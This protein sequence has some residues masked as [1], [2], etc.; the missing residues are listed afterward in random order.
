MDD[1]GI[2]IPVTRMGQ[3]LYF[4]AHGGDFN[5]LPLPVT[6]EDHCWYYIC[7]YGIKTFINGDSGSVWH[8]G[9]TEPN[10]TTPAD[11]KLGDYY[12]NT[13]NGKYYVKNTETT[14]NHIGTLQGIA[15]ADGQDG[16][17]WLNGEANPPQDS[18]G[19]EGDYYLNNTSGVYWKKVQNVWIEQGTLRGVNGVAGPK[20][21]PG[22]RGSKWFN[23]HYPDDT[24]VS[25]YADGDHFLDIDNGDIKE[26]KG[27]DWIDVMNI[28][29]SKLF[30]G[31]G[32][33]P[34]PT[35]DVVIKDGDYH[36]NNT[37]G[38]Y[39]ERVAGVWQ[40]KGTLKGPK[41]DRGEQGLPGSPGVAGQPGPAGSPG[42]QGQPGVAGKAGTAWHVGAQPPA[43][44]VND[45]DLH[46][47]TNGDVSKEVNGQWINQNI[48]LKG[49]KGDPGPAGKDATT[50]EPKVNRMSGADL[51][52]KVENNGWNADGSNA[53]VFIRN[54]KTISLEGGIYWNNRGTANNNGYGGQRIFTI[55]SPGTRPTKDLV[56]CVATGN[57]NT[58]LTAPGYI[59]VKKDGTISLMMGNHLYVSLSGISW[60]AQGWQ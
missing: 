32:T 49:P 3:Y 53:P 11:S 6:T 2:N 50:T 46:L 20:G 41:G 7:K 5:T 35:T 12:I 44:T 15:G 23:G 28:R 57:T 58:S 47:A 55:P 52:N 14:W 54:G 36:I 34:E 18:E 40:P 59:A 1:I 33:L 17:S 31:D 22:V 13:S 42:P 51:T 25:A 10:E 45:G 8:N 29:G 4:L 38:E 21:D 43:D 16:A 30:N 60:T 24:N 56:F 27:N 39:H 48:N 26:R 37:S 9:A 19:K